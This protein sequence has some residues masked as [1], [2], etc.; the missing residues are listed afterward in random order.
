MEIVLASQHVPRV[1]AI[2][3]KGCLPGAQSGNGTSLTTVPCQAGL[4][5]PNPEG[6]GSPFTNIH[7]A[8][9]VQFCPATK[10]GCPTCPRP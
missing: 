4:Q 3:H 6:E 7:M 8:D 10:Q 5:I 9:Q 2:A 1:I